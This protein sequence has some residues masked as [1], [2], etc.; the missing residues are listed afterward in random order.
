MAELETIHGYMITAYSCECLDHPH[1]HLA[2]RENRWQLTMGGVAWSHCEDQT[3]EDIKANHRNV[4][5]I[6]PN[7]IRDL[8]DQINHWKMRALEAEAACRG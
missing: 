8:L 4:K 5:P 1:Q 3:V 6:I 2:R 7:G